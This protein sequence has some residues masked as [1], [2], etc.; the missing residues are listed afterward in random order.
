M[1][2]EG[3]YSFD[4]GLTWMQKMIRKVHLARQDLPWLT[5][6]SDGRVYAIVSNFD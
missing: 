6:Q 5:T 1:H 2:L 4:N 3:S